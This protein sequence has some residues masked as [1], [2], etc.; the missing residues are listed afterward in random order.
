MK[1][2]HFQ[3]WGVLSTRLIY[4]YNKV[5]SKV[6]FLVKPLP[7][8]HIGP[9]QPGPHPEGHEPV[10]KLHIPLSR[11]LP[12]SSTQLSP[13]YPSEHSTKEIYCISPYLA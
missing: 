6:V 9:V 10:S 3:F 7:V 4:F 13:K 1:V 8:L 5:I 12:H 11:Q 2:D